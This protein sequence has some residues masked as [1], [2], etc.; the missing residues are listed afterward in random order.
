MLT[1]LPLL[2]SATLRVF[3]VGPRCRPLAS[4]SKVSDA[5]VTNRQCDN[6]GSTVTDFKRLTIHLSPYGEK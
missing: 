5:E 6:F 1:I 2:T 3:G 4:A